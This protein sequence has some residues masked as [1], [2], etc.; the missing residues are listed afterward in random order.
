MSTHVV[1]S[2]IMHIGSV[3]L[4]IKL[5]DKVHVIFKCF[6]Q[7]HQWGLSNP[8]ILYSLSNLEFKQRMFTCIELESTEAAS[9][10]S[11]KTATF[12]SLCESALCNLNCNSS[13]SSTDSTESLVGMQSDD[14]ERDKPDSVF[15]YKEC[16]GF[17]RL[18]VPCF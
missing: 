5:G 9:S 12:D 15:A 13:L 6:F 16:F 2:I 7:Q 8:S 11:I 3:S 18:L 10:K 14:V 1:K 17:L 4:T